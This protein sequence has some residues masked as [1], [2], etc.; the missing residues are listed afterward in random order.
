MLCGFLAGSI[1]TALTH[2]QDVIKTRLQTLPPRVS[3]M[4]VIRDIWKVREVCYCWFALPVVPLLLCRS[5]M[6]PNA[7]QRCGLLLP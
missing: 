3:T 1:A 2:P 4:Q 5:H 6:P 7:R